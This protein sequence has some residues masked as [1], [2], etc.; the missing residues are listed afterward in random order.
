[1]KRGTVIRLS[2]K[3][4]CVANRVAVCSVL[5]IL[6]SCVL[7]TAQNVVLTGALCGRVTD[8]SGA[9]VP[10]ASVVVHNLQT[11][12]EQSAETNH[13]GL[14]QFPVLAPG[15]YSIAASL[16][17]FRDVRA[18]VRVQVGN[19]ASL[20]IKLKVGASGDA[21][22]VTGTTPLLRPEESSASTVLEGAFIDDL[23]LNGRRYTDFTVLSPNT[24]YDGDTGL[25]SIAGQQG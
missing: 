15:F 12:V 24:S 14:Y 13:S 10:G 18:L 6:A 17:G 23:P 20:D 1:M 11:A 4:L 2:C 22:T 9:V 21:V 19:T 25:V 7:L 5:V 8:P 16:N 3:T